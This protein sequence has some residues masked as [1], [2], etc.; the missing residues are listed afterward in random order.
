MAVTPFATRET[1]QGLHLAARSA[2]VA[3]ASIDES[4]AID[5]MRTTW[6]IQP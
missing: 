2:S 4:A 1:R 5:H 6:Q 3:T